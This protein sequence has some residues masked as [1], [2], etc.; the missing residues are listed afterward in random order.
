MIHIQIQSLCGSIINNKK[1]ANFNEKIYKSK[2]KISDCIECERENFMIKPSQN[3]CHNLQY[4]CTCCSSILEM[5]TE[6]THAHNQ[7]FQ[8]CSIELLISGQSH[9]ECTIYTH[10]WVTNQLKSNRAH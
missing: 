1:A 3:N 2:S 7:T 4:I 5:S 10:R 6:C 9:V 8:V